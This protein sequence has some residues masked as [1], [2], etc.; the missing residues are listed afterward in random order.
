M[1]PK[2]WL[3]VAAVM[4]A[5]G[6]ALGAFGAHGLPGYLEGLSLN[7]DDLAKRLDNFETAVRYHM[8]HAL[9]LLGVA[10]LSRFICSGWISIAGWSFLTGTVLFSGLLYAYALTG[11]KTLGMIVPFGGT[12]LIVG[13]IALAIAA[14]NNRGDEL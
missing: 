6:V 7:Q 14:I 9:A 12:L 8:Y 13:W 3:L 4:G 2:F 1:K 11:V 5:I 10:L